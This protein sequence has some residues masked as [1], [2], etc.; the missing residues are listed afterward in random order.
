MAASLSTTHCFLPPHPGPA[1][2]VNAFKA[3]MGKTLLYGLCIAIPAVI[4]VGPFLGRRLKTIGNLF[5]QDN[6]VEKEDEILPAAAPSFLIALLPV[7]FISL[8]VIAEIFL[9]AGILKT[10][11]LLP[12]IPPSLY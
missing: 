10:I 2:L 7:I 3:D 6:Q 9:P 1:L 8:S 11:F 5:T 12:E 4:L